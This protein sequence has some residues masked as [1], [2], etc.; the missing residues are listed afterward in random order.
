LIIGGLIL[1]LPQQ[2]TIGMRNLQQIFDRYQCDKGSG[3]HR[4]YKEYEIYMEKFRDKP[5]KILEVGTYKGASIESWRE[6]FS[7]DSTIYTMDIFTRLESEDVDVLKK[8]NVKWM[9]ADSTDKDLPKIIKEEWGDD[10]EFDFIID[11]G[12]HYPDANRLTFQN[13][14]PFLKEGGKYF[15]E[16]VIPMHRMTDA[17]KDNNSHITS[18][19]MIFN[20]KTYNKWMSY[21][22][23]YEHKSYDRRNEMRTNDT[24][25]MVVDK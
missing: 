15:I 7:D 4:Y 6:Y 21:M 10:I 12:A 11:D 9:Q 19:K 8:D 22:T 2:G 16:D 23:N 18:N 5:I 25:I 1:I 17:E 20:N 3:R 24:Y 14:Y 13:L